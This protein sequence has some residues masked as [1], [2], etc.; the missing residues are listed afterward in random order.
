MH[1]PAQRFGNFI[2]CLKQAKS[3]TTPGRR[4]V[5]RPTG[6]EQLGFYMTVDTER[7]SYTV[8]GSPCH[9]IALT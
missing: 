1:E 2:W 9:I 8:L 4:T 7:D 6:R 3:A 5:E